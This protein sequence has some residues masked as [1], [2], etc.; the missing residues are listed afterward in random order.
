MLAKTD[1]NRFLQRVKSDVDFLGGGKFA[2]IS[3]AIA[4]DTKETSLP[5]FP[6]SNLEPHQ[7]F[8][9]R[10][11][12]RCGFISGLMIKFTAENRVFFADFAYL[13]EKKLQME[14]E[15]IGRR[16]KNG[17]ASLS[18]KDLA[19]NGHEIFLHKQNKVWDYLSVLVSEKKDKI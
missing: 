10:D 3:F 12:H 9:L 15:K 7:F 11:R 6:L 5:R 1:N 13:N 14:S 16:A 18:I 2:G 17:T 8:K 19:E 4:F